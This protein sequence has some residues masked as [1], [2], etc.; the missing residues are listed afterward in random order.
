MKILQGS[1]NIAFKTSVDNGVNFTY[2]PK[3]AV[4][5]VGQI[6]IPNAGANHRYPHQDQ[7]MVTIMGVNGKIIEQFDI[8]DITGQGGWVATPAGLQQAVLDI[9]SWL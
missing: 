4:A 9:Q 2:T 8:Q 7:L 1:A 3:V 5:T 6:Y